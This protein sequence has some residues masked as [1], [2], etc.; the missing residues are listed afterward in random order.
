MRDFAKPV[1]TKTVFEN[2]I[3]WGDLRI[4][5]PVLLFFSTIMTVL[6]LGA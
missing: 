3:T 5:I 1:T 2:D 4:T 6:I